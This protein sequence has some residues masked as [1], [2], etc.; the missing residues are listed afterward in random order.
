M[1]VASRMTGTLA[2][3]GAGDERLRRREGHRPVRSSSV[4]GDR[5]ADRLARPGRAAGSRV[6]DDLR[7]GSN[8]VR[9]VSGRSSVTRVVLPLIAEILAGRELADSTR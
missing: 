2:S 7:A 5:A 8:H 4:P 9:S 6:D 1:I 3:G